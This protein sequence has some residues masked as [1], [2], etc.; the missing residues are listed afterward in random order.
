M[1]KADL[2]VSRETI[3]KLETYVELLKK[4]N[5]R[6]NL[7]SKSTID[8]VWQR[9]IQD[10][11]QIFDLA[12]VDFQHWVDLG[13]GG[14]FPGLVCAILSQ[15]R[16]PQALFT[17]VESDA[18]KSVFLRTVIREIGLNAQ[19]ITD[20]IEQ[21]LPLNADVLSARALADLSVLLEFSQR[22]MQ[23]SGIALF[24][25]GVNWKNE[26]Q[27]AEASWFFEWEQTK[28]KT[29][30]GAVILRIGGISRV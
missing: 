14:G 20:R 26:V 25:K 1:T 22:H 23:E 7:V 19:V 12:P 16:N 17:L 10:S 21:T 30:P 28:S 2:D 5:P 29:E 24:P 3:E 4:W 6:I 11:A 8:A 27:T 13:S 9:H 15:G 18:R